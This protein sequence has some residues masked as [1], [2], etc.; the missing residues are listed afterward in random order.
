MRLWD[1]A[2]KLY[3][4][5]G[6]APACLTLQDQHGVDVNQLMF[7]AWMGFDRGILM[8]P[9]EIAGAA[10]H[11][12]IWVG[13]VVNPLRE[14]RRR[15]KNSALSSFHPAS[16]ELRE[17]VKGLELH[18]EKLQLEALESWAESR[19]TQDAAGA[20]AASGFKN[21][22]EFLRMQ[23]PAEVEPAVIAALHASLQQFTL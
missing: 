16:S 3:A 4:R 23:T 8:A 22:S 9:Q 17:Q 14:V 1:F 13:H 12:Q 6:V 2:T 18:A 20:G 19:F 21:L 7:A 11:V 15:M 10:L 5:P